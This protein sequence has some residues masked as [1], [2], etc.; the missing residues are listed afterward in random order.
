MPTI[1]ISLLEFPEIVLKMVLE[2]ADFRSILSIRKVCRDLRHFIDDTKPDFKISLIRIQWHSHSIG[3]T[4]HS[5][6]TKPI[7]LQYHKYKYGEPIRNRKITGDQYLDFFLKDFKL[8]LENQKSKMEFFCLSIDEVSF[9]PDKKEFMTEIEQILEHSKNKLKSINI[10]FDGNPHR[11]LEILK[12]LDP[13]SL[14]S[15]HLTSRWNAYD[16]VKTE[17]LM[18]LEQWKQAEELITD[19]IRI[20]GPIQNIWHF[21]TL[22]TYITH[23]SFQELSLLKEGCLSKLFTSPTL[24]SFQL[25]YGILDNGDDTQF[26]NSFIRIF[27]EPQKKEIDC[28][29]WCLNMPN[30]QFLIVST[31]FS[32]Y[33]I[34]ISRANCVPNSDYSD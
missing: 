20:S 12:Y 9:E 6:V 26:K 19:N 5:P 11:L 1:P 22:K 21:S 18:K 23:L 33:T 31:T 2:K 8:I 13:K 17:E 7:L 29:E 10:R 30:R 3:F 27:G 32:R 28:F 24:K 4:L 14:K 25:R 16:N 34:S 15:I